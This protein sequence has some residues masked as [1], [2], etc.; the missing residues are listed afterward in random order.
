MFI[1]FHFFS[2]GQK[3]LFYYL[4]QL[5]NILKY[6]PYK[7]QIHFTPQISGQQQLRERK[8]QI[9][10]CPHSPFH[11]LHDSVPLRKNLRELVNF[12]V[13]QRNRCT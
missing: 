9:N 12:A 8:K 2:S 10:P 11:H 5:A 13:C 6:S 4:E 3:S 1:Y 7:L